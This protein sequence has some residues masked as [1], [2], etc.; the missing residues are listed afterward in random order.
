MLEIRTGFGPRSSSARKLPF[1][2]IRTSSCSPS[3]RAASR[4]GTTENSMVWPGGKLPAVGTD[5]DLIC[6]RAERVSHVEVDE[7]RPVTGPFHGEVETQ[8]SDNLV[9]HDVR[10]E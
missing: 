2:S 1:K 6:S 8:I 10:P 5:S 7:V 4:G 9:Q 3:R